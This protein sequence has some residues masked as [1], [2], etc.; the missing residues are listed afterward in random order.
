MASQDA[1]TSLAAPLCE[2]NP[3]TS[4]AVDSVVDAV[5]KASL[6]DEVATDVDRK[7]QDSDPRPLRIY[8]CHDLLFL[9][10]SPLIGL[11]EGMP[12]FKDW[13]GD[14]N[15][16]VG[17]KKE[18]EGTANTTARDRR[19]RRDAEDGDSSRVSFRSGLTQPSQ[20]GNF[21]HQSIRTTERG[22][23]KDVD[24]ERE[25]DLRDREGQERLR[26]PCPLSLL[27]VTKIVM[28][29]HTSRALPQHVSAK[30]PQPDAV[31]KPETQRKGKQ[32]RA[33]MTGAEVGMKERRGDG[34]RDDRRDKDDTGRRDLDDSHDR[35]RFDHGRRN[36]DDGDD[37]PRRWRD[38]GR[39]EE[40]LAARR[41][42]DRWDRFE[43]RDRERPSAGDDRDTRTRRTGA[44]E[45]RFGGTNDDVKDRE[46]RRDRDKDREA[47]PAWMETYIPTTPGAGILGGKGPDGELDGIQAWK[48]GMKEKERKEKASD[49]A[50]S[51]K[52]T[53]VNG[54]EQLGSST[55]ENVM[56]E[57]QLFKLMMKREAEKKET[58]KPQN[59]Q[60]DLRPSGLSSSPSLHTSRSESAP[61]SVIV[62]QSSEG[63]KTSHSLTSERSSPHPASAPSPSHDGQ[64]SLNV[65]TSDIGSIARGSGSL[66]P[67]LDRALE[68]S[69]VMG[70]R[71]AQAAS[72]SSLAQPSEF[73]S[74]NSSSSTFNP[75]AGS[76]VLAF[77][78]RTP[79]AGSAQP[80]ALNQISPPGLSAPQ[81]SALSSAA[82]Q[83]H[84]SDAPGHEMQFGAPR[85]NS[86]D[87]LRGVR[88]FS[89]LSNG[90]QLN[91]GFEELRESVH[92]GHLNE[93]IRRV[94][95][96][97]TAERAMLGMPGENVPSFNELG[98]AYPP[99]VHLDGSV[100]ANFAGNKG[101]R[102]AKFFDAK[103]RETQAAGPRLGQQVSPAPPAIPHPRQESI[104]LGQRERTME[105]IFAML[106][107]SSQNHRMSPQNPQPGRIPQSGNQF[108]QTN[109]ELQLLQQQQQQQLHQQQLA[110]N[111]R[112]ESL[113]DSRLDDRN[114]VPDGLVPGLRPAP[115]RSRS[116]ESGGV[117]FNEQIDDPLHFNVQRLTQQRNLEQMYNG[118]VPSMYSQQ[119]GMLRNGGG[120]SIQQGQFRGASPISG[121]N[122]PQPP[123]QRLPPGLANLGGRPPHDPSQFLG[124][125]VGM[126]GGGL[127]G[128]SPA[129]QVYNTFTQGN[130]GFNGA[131]PMRGPPVSQTP[132][133]LNAMGG[134][135]PHNIDLRA[136]NQAQ[137]LGMAQGTLGGA[138]G[139]RGS[140]PGFGPQQGPGGQL[141]PSH[142]AMRQQLQQQQQQQLPP[143]MM[144]HLLPS[145]LQQQGMSGGNAQTTQDLMAL[146]MG[147]HRE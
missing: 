52:V 30:A 44:R 129:Q 2:Q 120:L 75:P 31:L 136:A 147:G 121:Q 35:D 141:G 11:P 43:E 29:L 27:F 115:P 73:A 21:R 140:G 131:P 139:L 68:T 86:T 34:N 65:I 132:L 123:S 109:L 71:L 50:E 45:R 90:S 70:P 4:D 58:E 37:D 99:G 93:G 83:P 26:N 124:A 118:P 24:K 126:P 127:H 9:S 51:S 19:F 142:I 61:L 48:K 134:L 5:A 72:A 8:T 25:R 78:S 89:P 112:L 7:S 14:W 13:F 10:R 12:A 59:G 82:L 130:L 135:G 88:S 6:Q 119:P 42:R 96:S 116:R 108:S 111:N 102:F 80:T 57:I 106:Q 64:P 40:R 66:S 56:D 101:S 77:K 47:E 104:P 98:G 62:Q 15:E 97:S 54:A 38:D 87:G 138:A 69:R 143:H 137:L 3:S 60:Q 100:P 74:S 92:L 133:S 146:L 16:Q 76:R 95:G 20:M 117:L 128:A 28:L 49:T 1:D 114:F 113:Y 32:A 36:K 46:E 105:D 125:G 17:T 103:T 91:A 23:E 107:S 63:S 94:S 144:P 110:Q 18:T 55:A 22:S 84:L 145:H 122:P 53:P 67:A 39:R 41:D 33:A 85:L 79:A 81:R